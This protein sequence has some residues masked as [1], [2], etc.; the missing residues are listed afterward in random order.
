MGGRLQGPVGRREWRPVERSEWRV[1]FFSS[2]RSLFDGMSLNTALMHQPNPLCIIR[3]VGAVNC[4]GLSVVYF[5]QP[6]GLGI[7]VGW[8]RLCINFF[9]PSAQ[10]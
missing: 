1:F 5:S 3:P 8:R 2:D 9:S 6:V 10:W 7:N 4:G